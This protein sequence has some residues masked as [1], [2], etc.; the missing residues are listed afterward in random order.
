M[1]DVADVLFL[2]GML[3]I[4]IRRFSRTPPARKTSINE[5]AKLVTVSNSC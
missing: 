1:Q 3:A 5:S 4:M 2:V